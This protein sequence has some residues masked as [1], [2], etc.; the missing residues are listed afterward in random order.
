LKVL[1]LRTFAPA[2]LFTFHVEGPSRITLAGGPAGVN[3][4]KTVLR[5]C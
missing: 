3:R 4:A 1:V 5:R 2:S